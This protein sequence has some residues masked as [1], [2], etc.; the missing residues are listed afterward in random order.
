MPLLEL[1]DFILEALND[2]ILEA[3]INDLMTEVG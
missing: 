3:L 2:E 1:N